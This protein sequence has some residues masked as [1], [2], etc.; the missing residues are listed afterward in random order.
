MDGFRKIALYG[1]NCAHNNATRGIG[2][3]ANLLTTE[4]DEEI[5]KSNATRFCVLSAVSI[6]CN[7]SWKAI[8]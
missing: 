1:G 3:E 5:L 7:Q 2:A 6:K 8:R 4:L